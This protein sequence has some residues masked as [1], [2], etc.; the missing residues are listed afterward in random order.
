[1]KLIDHQSDFQVLA[2]PELQN[3]PLLV[4]ANK[5]EF[6]A[7]SVDTLKERLNLAKVC[8]SR[9]WKIAPMSADM[10]TSMALT[11]H[12]YTQAKKKYTYSTTTIML[13]NV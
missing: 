6:E 9:P 7:L 12:M 1:M 13:S 10:S 5:Q 3:M 8:G 4:F 2:A 11:I